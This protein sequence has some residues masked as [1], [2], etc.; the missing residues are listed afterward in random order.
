[1]KLDVYSNSVQLVGAIQGLYQ[2]GGLLGTIWT[3]IY[4]DALGRRLAICLASIFCIVG[5][6]LQ[7]GSV[8]VAMFMVA[9]FISGLGIGMQYH[10][11]KLCDKVG[12]PD[13]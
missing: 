2:A 11:H 10:D 6:A 5:G 13:W 8:H 4:G 12:S 3:G 9:R 1:M 7:T